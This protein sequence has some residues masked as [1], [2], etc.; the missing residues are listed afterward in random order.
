MSPIGEGIKSVPKLAC[1]VS[2]SGVFNP[3]SVD[4]LKPCVV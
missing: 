3:W 2:I 1:V 4:E